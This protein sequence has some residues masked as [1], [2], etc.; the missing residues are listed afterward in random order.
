MQLEAVWGWISLCSC[1]LMHFEARRFD[2]KM[3]YPLAQDTGFGICD[4][5]HSGMHRSCQTQ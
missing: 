4:A 3:E 2:W 5:L 1:R